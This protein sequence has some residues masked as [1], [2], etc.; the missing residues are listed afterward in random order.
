MVDAM[1]VQRDMDELWRPSKKLTEARQELQEAQDWLK[2]CNLKPM[3]S[4]PVPTGNTMPR[5]GP[6]TPRHARGT[7]VVSPTKTGKGASPEKEMPRGQETPSQLGGRAS[8]EK[9]VGSGKDEPDTSGEGSE[10]GG[11]SQG[12]DEVDETDNKAVTPGVTV[13]RRGTQVAELDQQEFP[14]MGGKWAGKGAMRKVAEI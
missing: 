6:E 10:D 14:L 8:P 7:T 12:E 11:S 4:T 13:T 3:P 5:C 9:Q 1:V 2:G